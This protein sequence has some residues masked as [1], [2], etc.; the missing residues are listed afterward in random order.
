MV[1]SAV[2]INT[3]SLRPMHERCL[4]SAQKVK[5]RETSELDSFNGTSAHG[6]RGLLQAQA[7]D[8]NT[9][10]RFRRYPPAQQAGAS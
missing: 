8:R 10:N 3:Q 5:I 9:D 7:P 2:S 6:R 1:R 4:S